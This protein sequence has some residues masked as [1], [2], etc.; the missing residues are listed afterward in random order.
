MCRFF[1]VWSILMC[2]SSCSVLYYIL[3]RALLCCLLLFIWPFSRMAFAVSAFNL[4]HILMEHDLASLPPCLSGLLP[5]ATARCPHFQVKLLGLLL[6]QMLLL[7]QP[8]AVHGFVI[9]STGSS[10]AYQ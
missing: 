2:S 7:A 5:T 1:S 8:A 6:A 4:L 9:D 10:L 3:T